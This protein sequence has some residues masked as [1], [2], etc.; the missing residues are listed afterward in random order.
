MKE[1]LNIIIII[2]ACIS[3]LSSTLVIF[4]IF[5][6]K[7]KDWAN[8]IILAL[9][10]IDFL[11]SALAIMDFTQIS[12]D[13]C[14]I[15]YSLMLFIRDL[16]KVIVVF[17]SIALYKSV[18]LETHFTKKL[19]LLYFSMSIGIYL[20]KSILLIF[21]SKFSWIENMCLIAPVD[22]EFDFIITFFFEIVISLLI[23]IYIGILYNKV[24]QKLFNEALVC[25]LYSTKKRFYAK[26]LIGFGIVFSLIITPTLVILVID[27]STHTSDDIFL[28]K[29]GM[30]S[31]CWYPF[32]NSL[33][34][35]F[36]KSFTRNIFS[37]CIKSPKFDLQ[38]ETLFLLRSEQELRPRYYLDLLGESESV[39][40]DVTVDVN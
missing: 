1:A 35:G 39:I 8:L 32:L 10:T 11:M 6:I 3:L 19:A 21:E 28:A 33:M 34:Y 15:I 13:F 14:L 25:N 31:Y 26:R 2:G 23:L 17:M 7:Y 5:S 29:L 16:H 30:L 18:V 12:N 27:I 36:T 9:A 22:F 38:E 37:I 24:R 40:F 20:I 4:E